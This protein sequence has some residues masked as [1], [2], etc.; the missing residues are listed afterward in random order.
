MFLKSVIHLSILH[1]LSGAV[2]TQSF[3]W[4]ILCAI[5]KLFN[6]FSAAL[7]T[8]MVPSFFIYPDNA[9][10]HCD[11]AETTVFIHRWSVLTLLVLH[12]DILWPQFSFII[13][14]SSH[15][16]F[17]LQYYLYHSFPSSSI[18]LHIAHSDHN[19]SSSSTLLIL[20]TVLPW[21]QCFFVI[22]IAHSG[23]STTLTTPKAWSWWVTWM[24]TNW[25]T[26]TL[27]S[28]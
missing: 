13:D 17:C 27:P 14:L 2:N 19:V 7:T 15:C 9:H 5:H 28:R 6:S 8:N 16:S 24:S 26:W 20:V 11:T 23:Y 4:K 18:C 22:H 1:H 25:K 12:C 3:V 21:P 10:S